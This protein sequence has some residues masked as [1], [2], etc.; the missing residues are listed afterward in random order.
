MYQAKHHE[1]RVAVYDAARDQHS[2]ARLGLASD[3]RQALERSELKL[4]YQPKVDLASGQVVGAEAL[5]RWQHS[6]QG[7]IPPDQ[8]IGLAEQTGLIHPVT[9][10]VVEEAL[11]Q[12]RAWRS[13]GL[14]VP[15]A[16][17]FS[18]RNLQEPEIVDVVAQLLRRW[19]VPASMLEIEMTESSLMADPARALD[20]LR[21][22]RGMGVKIAIDDFGTGYSSLAH[23]KQLPVDVLKIDR[24]FVREMQHDRSD[25]LIVRTTVDL[26]HHLG[27]RV[28]AEGIEDA[29]TAGYLAQIG[30]DQAQGYYFARPL[31]A[32]DLTR[33]L[34][35]TAPNWSTGL[36]KA[37]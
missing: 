9:L 11:R 18:M 37:A 4:H 32:N 30:C 14:Q 5:L 29:A 7:Q 23:L 17:N 22:L 2:P 8:F 34:R 35:E 31:P 27:L 6:T 36:R 3:L 20:A 10:W 33:W 16:V 12:H 1:H 25:Q 26:A 13:E 21:R 15:V 24:S 28:V 19:E